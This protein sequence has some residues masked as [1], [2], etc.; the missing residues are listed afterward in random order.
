MTSA[1]A[2]AIKVQN[3]AKEYE[4]EGGM[5][6]VFEDV[7][8]E[9][10]PSSF[11]TLIGKSGSG[12]STLLDIV[13]GITKA[14][15]GSVTFDPPDV[16]LGHVFQSPRLLPWRTCLK[17]IEY[18]HKD[19]PDYTDDLAKQYLD[20]VGLSDH[21]NKYPTQLSGGQQQRVGIA[22][23]LSIDPEILLMDEP[24]SNLD[25]ITAESLRQELLQ[26]WGELN[27][28]I[29]FVT[30]DITEAIELSDR[31]LMIGNGEIY[32]DVSV[33][34]DRPRD[35]ESNEFLQFRQQAIDK[36]HSIE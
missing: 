29:F 21:Y 24:F 33:D 18:V 4:T 31:I 19:N 23:A 2:G 9:I 8:F 27:K 32:G 11:V 34:L 30:H 10:E 12:K 13:S 22:R 20:M 26:I 16:E 6:L 15:A 28:T 14:T 5:E 7:S 3:L 17:N 36:F 25:E 1:D 35:L